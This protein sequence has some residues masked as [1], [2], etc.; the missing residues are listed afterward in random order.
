[1]PPRN[2]RAQ[3]AWEEN[4]REEACMN[5]KAVL[6]IES[7]AREVSV[8]WTARAGTASKV[9]D[10]QTQ[11]VIMKMLRARRAPIRMVRSIH[12]FASVAKLGSTR[13][14]KARRAKIHALFARQA[15]IL[16]TL[17]QQVA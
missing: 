13:I 1:M 4:T 15:N 9:M 8:S 11:F 14:P 5:V 10:C 2:Q 17:L 12:S 7:L 3:L 16:L 6:S